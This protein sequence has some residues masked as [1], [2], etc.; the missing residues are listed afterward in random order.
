[1]PAQLVGQPFAQQSIQ[2]EAHRSGV[3]LHRQ[4]PPPQTTDGRSLTQIRRHNL[5]PQIDQLAELRPR[6]LGVPGLIGNQTGNRQVRLRRDPAF[7]QEL[8]LTGEIPH[9]RI[10]PCARSN[11]REFS[12]CSDLLHVIGR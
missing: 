2:L 8:K 12:V 9:D 4:N 7:T 3:R 6:L 1:M 5:K 10:L 11:A